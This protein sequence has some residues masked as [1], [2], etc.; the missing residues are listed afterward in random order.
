MTTAKRRRHAHRD[1][2]RFAVCPLSS[3]IDTNAM[4][5][6]SLS[7]SRSSAVTNADQVLWNLQK[8]S[9]SS[10]TQVTSQSAASQRVH[11]GFEE[12]THE[13]KPICGSLKNQ[14]TETIDAY[15]NCPACKKLLRRAGA[16]LHGLYDVGDSYSSNAD[17]FSADY[18]ADPT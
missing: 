16:D 2:L 13:T 5:A 1:R 15:A 18:D 8:A 6:Y 10:L 3:D 11:V 4:L 9:S 17:R 7:M 12:G 14:A